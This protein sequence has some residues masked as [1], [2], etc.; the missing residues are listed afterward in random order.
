MKYINNY[1]KIEKLKNVKDYSVII[2]FDHTLTTGNS[3]TSYGII[4]SYLGGEVQEEREKIFNHY[5]PIEL[6][7]TISCQEKETLMKQWAQS[8]FTLLSKHTTKDIVNKAVENANLTLR[9]GTKEWF[10][11]MHKENIPVIVMSAGIGNII[12]CFL[13]KQGVLYS[14]VIIFSNFFTFSKDGKAYID[15]EN[16]IP[17]ANKDY[18]LLPENI[19]QIIEKSRKVLLFGDIIEDIQ[20]INKEQRDK[21]ITIGFLD[22]NISE[23][24]TTYLANYDVVLTDKEG[25]FNVQEILD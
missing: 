5:R 20:M 8:S 3:N 15:I 6:D 24:L 16:V 21:T 13:E 1:D 9:P 22:H 10:E 11:R 2:D 25:F 12:E 14:N 19:K 18:K 7:Y 4:P 23:N 17:T